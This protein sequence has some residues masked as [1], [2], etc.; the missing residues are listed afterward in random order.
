MGAFLLEKVMLTKSKADKLKRLIKAV[1]E[2]NV[3]YSW[4]GAGDPA[5]EPILKKELRLANYK[6]HRFVLELQ[7]LPCNSTPR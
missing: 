6:L 2:A 3:Q 1:V 5:D 7:G 4:K